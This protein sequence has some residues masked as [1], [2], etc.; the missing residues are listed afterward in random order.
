M[1]HKK[2]GVGL[3][4]LGLIS[5]AHMRGYQEAEEDASV[6]AVCDSNGS[7]AD[8][9][10]KNFGARAYT[11]YSELLADPEVQLVDITLPHNLH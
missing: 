2:I 5:R 3:I 9:V 8:P 4:G 10:A 7:I 1:N 6:I 11:R